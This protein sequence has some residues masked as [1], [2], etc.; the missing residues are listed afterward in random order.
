M[1]TRTLKQI[2]ASRRNGAMSR[3]PVPGTMA[4]EILESR[5]QL[6]AGTV[7][8]REEAKNRF[9][10]L[11]ESMFEEWR[12]ANESEAALVENMVMARW[13]QLRSAGFQTEIIGNGMEKLQGSGPSR[14]SI[15]VAENE[16]AIVSCLRS[17]TIYERQYHRA[18]R[19]LTHLR[20]QR[21]RP[22]KSA[23]SPLSTATSTWPEEPGDGGDGGD[24]PHCP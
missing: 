19:S 7:V 9:I 3:G 10:S 22:G 18:L 17:E 12:P 6:L 20:L 24:G 2:E 16:H 11:M 14:A 1:G 23:S 5:K 8:L 21:N 13:R 15:A 4:A